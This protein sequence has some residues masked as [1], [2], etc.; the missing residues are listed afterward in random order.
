MQE[1][2][3]YEEGF[4]LEMYNVDE[5]SGLERSI[6]GWIRN[7]SERKGREIAR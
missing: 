2:A 5:E 1:I 7:V 3:I 4:H 6:G